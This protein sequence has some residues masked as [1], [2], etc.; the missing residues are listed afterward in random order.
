MKAQ[1][2]KYTF[3]ISKDQN[4]SNYLQPLPDYVRYQ[5]T[6]E[7][8]YCD[9]PTTKRILEITENNE[10][11]HDPDFFLPSRILNLTHLVFKDPPRY[12]TE[13]ISLLAWVP[14]QDVD[15]FINLKKEEENAQI[16]KDRENMVWKSN[17]LFKLKKKELVQKC[18]QMTINQDGTK[19]DLI[20]RLWENQEDHIYE[21]LYT[22]ELET[23]PSTISGITSMSISAIR[24]ILAHHEVKTVGSKEELVLRLFMLKHQP[25]CCLD[26]KRE[27][28][29]DLIKMCEH[30]L[31]IQVQ[32]EL[33]SLDSERMFP[34][35]KQTT[36]RQKV[37]NCP[38]IRPTVQIPA[39]VNGANLD[40]LFSPI[41]DYL[42][43]INKQTEINTSSTS[44]MCMKT[45]GNTI[46]VKWLKEE[47]MGTGWQPG[48][49]SATVLDYNKDTD[50]LTVEYEEEKN[51][52]YKMEFTTMVSKGFI[53]PSKPLLSMIETYENLL[54]IGQTVEIKWTH[55]ELQ[56][57]DWQAG[58]YEAVVVGVDFDEDTITVRYTEEKA[59]TY[60]IEVS[61]A[62]NS[63]MIRLK[64][65]NIK[66]VLGCDT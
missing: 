19:I 20:K 33:T 60:V 27:G 62:V 55:E 7:L 17:P 40:E 30:F 12:I 54:T 45:P 13:Q 49:Y 14:P 53:E 37:R 57:T 58:W 43:E 1:C 47:V 5:R 51:C 42:Q 66:T 31:K 56:G 2:N 23:V 8:H 29:L 9:H 22:G 61:P 50:E 36:T 24:I 26:G 44:F 59:C 16:E 3:K 65:N 4:E 6:E 46:K 48:W 25:D 18:K 28:L 64:K 11:K 39:H 34:S 52:T 21:E 35:N 32:M 63:S 15:K 10:I 41:K 38:I